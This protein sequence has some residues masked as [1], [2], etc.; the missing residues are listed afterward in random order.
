VEKDVKEKLITVAAKVNI[1]NLIVDS[2]PVCIKG[3]FNQ[4]ECL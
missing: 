1:I 3:F 4:E 2:L